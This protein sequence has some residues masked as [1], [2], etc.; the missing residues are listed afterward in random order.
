MPATRPG[1]AGQKT[2]RAG[3]RGSGETRASPTFHGTDLKA[4]FP[5]VWTRKLRLRERR[6]LAE[7]TKKGWGRPGEWNPLPRPRARCPARSQ[8]LRLWAGGSLCSAQR[9]AWKPWR[10]HGPETPGGAKAGPGLQWGEAGAAPSCFSSSSRSSL[11]AGQDAAS[12]PEGGAGPGSGKHHSPHTAH[13]GRGPACLGVL[14]PLVVS[15]FW[16][17]SG[18]LSTPQT[19]ASPPLPRARLLPPPPV[20]VPFCLSRERGGPGERQAHSF[21][22]SALCRASCFAF[23]GVQRGQGEVTNSGSGSLQKSLDASWIPGISA[24]NISTSWKD[25]T[26]PHPHLPQTCNYVLDT[27]LKPTIV[28]AALLTA[29]ESK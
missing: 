18:A 5:G 20:C 25:A 22:C 14:F 4:Q 23:G 15:A 11:H 1:E 10:P 13:G 27:G 16:S 3:P 12:R 2:S 7:F 26:H 9:A 24:C 6:D 29:N 28:Q 19:L 8:R 17:Q 21:A